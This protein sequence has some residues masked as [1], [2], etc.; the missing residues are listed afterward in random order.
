MDAKDQ[1]LENLR[2]E[3][4]KLRRE[5]EYQKLKV[6]GYE[7][8]LEIIK[9]EDGI[10]LLKKD[11]VTG[12]PYSLLVWGVWQTVENLSVEYPS[13][14][15]ATLCGLFGKTKQAYYMHK[16]KTFSELEVEQEILSIVVIY[17]AEMPII[18]GLKLYYL[19]SSVLGDAMDMGRDKFLCLLHRHKLII[20]PRKTHHT[21]NSNHVYFKYPNLVKELSICYVNQVWVSDITYIYTTDDKFC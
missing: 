1:A 3:N 13:E 16:R 17:R 2:V 12:S 8:L 5:V 21:T 7:R 11:C 19:V 4:E 15:M 9:H 18:G 10:D 20:P 6:A 14:T